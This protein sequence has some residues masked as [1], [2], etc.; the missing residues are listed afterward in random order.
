MIIIITF[1]YNYNYFLFKQLKL[2]FIESTL[3]L[4]WL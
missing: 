4:K 2:I 3:I 1:N